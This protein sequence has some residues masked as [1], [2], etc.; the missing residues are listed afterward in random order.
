MTMWEIS[1]VTSLCHKADVSY[2]EDKTVNV[3]AVDKG[4]IRRVRQRLPRYSKSSVSP[5]LHNG[6]EFFPLIPLLSLNCCLIFWFLLG[7][8]IHIVNEFNGH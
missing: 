7:V 6:T 5:N 3:T 4:F 2:S 1:C 8:L